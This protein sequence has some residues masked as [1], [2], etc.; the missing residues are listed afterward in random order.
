MAQ[1]AL[2]SLFDLL[3]E[4]PI[5]W[6]DVLFMGN[7]QGVTGAAMFV[8]LTN[9]SDGS[10]GYYGG[11]WGLSSGMPLDLRSAQQATT[12]AAYHVQG[13]SWEGTARRQADASSPSRMIRYTLN[14]L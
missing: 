13:N 11:L 5:T 1:A 3:W 9:S 14:V 2:G 12:F 6:G 10:S 4:T 7:D 8:L